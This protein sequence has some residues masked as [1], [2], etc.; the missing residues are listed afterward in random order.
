MNEELVTSS[1]ISSIIIRTMLLVSNI[2]GKTVPTRCRFSYPTNG[3]NNA[4]GI[5]QAKLVEVN[6]TNPP[7]QVV[8][9][10]RCTRTKRSTTAFSEF[11][12]QR[13]QQM[14]RIRVLSSIN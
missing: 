9:N 8:R 7:R 5:Y 4:N 10:R 6:D 14:P 11:G 1:D 3:S 12:L 13:G 2:S